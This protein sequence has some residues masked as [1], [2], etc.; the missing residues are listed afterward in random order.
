MARVLLRSIFAVSISTAGWA[1]A[2]A[3]GGPPNLA[4]EMVRDHN[5]V[6]AAL[7]LPP[8][9]WDNELAWHAQVWANQL[10]AE[11]GLRHSP[12]VGRP[13]EGENLSRIDGGH[14]SATALFSGW[15]DEGAQYRLAPLDC[16]DVSR[17]TVAGH[18]T[19]LMWRNTTR[20]GCAVAYSPR[21]Q[22]LV[23]RYAPPGNICGQTPY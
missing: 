11:S 14:T 8:V 3:Q 22:A 20:L 5:A 16:S 12:H 4:A 10:V 21:S 13:G 18:Y 23:C 9:T 19:Q 15:A 1:S 7:G 6:R 17:V 2:V